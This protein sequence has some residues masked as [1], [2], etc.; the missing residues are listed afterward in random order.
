M[1]YVVASK[2]KEANKAKGFNT[3]GDLND[4]LS[5]LVDWAL[6]Q[7][8]GRAKRSGRKTLRA[9][10]VIAGPAGDSKYVVA[11]KVKAANKSAGFNT[12]GD[13][14]GAVGSLIEW[15]VDQGQQRA[16][17]EGRKTVRGADVWA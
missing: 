13:A 5:S 16:K 17:A 3:A 9:L 4:G 7:G 6:A 14:I 1:S 12:A 8:Q 11:S 15:A 10:D 2:V